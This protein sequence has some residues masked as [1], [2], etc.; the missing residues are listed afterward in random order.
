MSNILKKFEKM[1][2]E[3]LNELFKSLNENKNIN[4]AYIAGW[5]DGDGCIDVG[6]R[7]GFGFGLKVADKEPVEMISE[8]FKCSLSQ[9]KMDPRP[10]FIKPPKKRYYVSVKGK[11]ALFLAKKIAPFMMEKTKNLYKLLENF[12]CHEKFPY[13]DLSDENFINYLI[14]FTE[15]EGCFI[16]NKE[17]TQYEFTITNT[18][19]NLLKY[20]ERRLKQ[21]GFFRFK[22]RTKHNGGSFFFNKEATNKII[23]RKPCYELRMYGYAVFDFYNLIKDRLIINRKKQKVLDT[24]EFLK[25]YKGLSYKR[26][27]NEKLAL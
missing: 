11:K 22:I 15:A 25:N 13:M 19:L 8:L 10:I 7:K 18:N 14:G 2:K 9:E 27:M 21:L 6:N 26:Y 23:K 24:L 1:N 20:L 5:I 12:E 4:W 17:R 16:F 3:Q